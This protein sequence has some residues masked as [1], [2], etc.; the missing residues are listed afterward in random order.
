MDNTNDRILKIIEASDSESIQLLLKIVDVKTVYEIMKA[1][2]GLDLF[3]PKLDR[4]LKTERNDNIKNDYF[5][6]GLTYPQ[7]SKKYGLTIRYIQ[8]LIRGD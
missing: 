5:N 3:I 1:Y 6:N 4:F 2:G 7:L 8:M